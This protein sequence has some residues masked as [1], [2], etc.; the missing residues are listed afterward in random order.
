MPKAKQV[1]T[2]WFNVSFRVEFPTGTDAAD[3]EEW[4]TELVDDAGYSDPAGP[5]DATTFVALPEDD[6]E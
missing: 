2:Q 5:Q 4:A 3:V 6:S 1:P